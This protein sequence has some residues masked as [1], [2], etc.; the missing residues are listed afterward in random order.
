MENRFLLFYVFLNELINSTQLTCFYFRWKP[1]TLTSPGGSDG[2]SSGSGHSPTSIHPGS[3]PP[4]PISS[5]KR[6]GYYDG[7]DGLPTKRPRISHYRKPSEPSY[8]P[9]IENN[10]Q[11]RPVTDSRDAGNMNPRSR[12]S[13]TNGYH[14]S[15]TNG[16]SDGMHIDKGNSSDEEDN[17]TGGKRVC[18]SH[19]LNH[20]VN[21]E[22]TFSKDSSR[23]LSPAKNFDRNRNRNKDEI[24]NRTNNNDVI[25]NGRYKENSEEREQKWN[26]I[27]S[28]SYN[29]ISRTSP[30]SQSVTKC[31]TD[32][33]P[34]QLPDD[35]KESKSAF[36][37]YLT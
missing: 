36:P 11:R 37:D 31:A 26:K 32:S 35:S 30:D 16:Y 2:G 4:P 24:G 21:Y 28:N 34:P 29:K 7:A 18:D 3:P 14:N 23:S 27:S 5:S 12:E 19:S 8:R 9:P 13:P 10:S 33:A 1:P 17:A 22:K 15:L 25:Y 20:G 6:P